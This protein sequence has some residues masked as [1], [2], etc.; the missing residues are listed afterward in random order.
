ML[1]IHAKDYSG[2]TIPII[3]AGDPIEHSWD[4][5]EPKPFIKGAGLTMS[6]V[7]DGTVSIENFIAD[8]DDF[9]YVEFRVNTLP[10][11]K[12]Y[13]VQD[14]YSEEMVDEDHVF[15]LKATD[16]L[17]L[18]K[19]VTLGEAAINFGVIDPLA[20]TI[21]QLAPNKIRVLGLIPLN[22]RQ[23]VRIESGTALDGDY[24]I[25]TWQQ[26][27]PHTDI[28]F[29]TEL[30]GTVVGS[31]AADLTFITP[32][33]LSTRLYLS[34]LIAL[35]LKPT[36]MAL[37]IRVYGTLFPMGAADDRFFDNT[38]IVPESFLNNG[39]WE[40]C[41]AVIEKTAGRAG[42][43]LIQAEGVLNF[44][45]FHELR[46]FG[47]A[48]PGYLYNSEFV[49]QSDIT[50][51]NEFTTGFEQLTEPETGISYTIARPMK[52]IRETFKYK[53]P[54]EI[55][56]NI[57]FEELG[58]FIEENTVGANTE[59]DYKMVGW[60][61]GF[62]YT[63]GGGGLIGSSSE[64][65]IRVVRDA[66]GREVER[67]G[68]VR[69]PA[70]F[71]QFAAIQS[72]AV[73][74]RI[75]DTIEWSFDFRTTRS[76]PGAFNCGFQVYITTTANPIPR[77]INNKRIRYD[78]DWYSFGAPIPPNTGPFTAISAGS[79][80]NQWQQFSITSL[81]IPVDGLL[82][83]Y[84]A[85]HS[86]SSSPGFETHYRNLKFKITR[87]VTSN[88]NVTGHQHTSAQL[89]DINNIQEADIFS[90]TSPSSTI[91]GT[92]MLDTVTGPLQDLTTTWDMG[93]D[94]YDTLGHVTTRE[95]LFWRRISRLVLEGNMYGLLQGG[96]ILS[97]IT[98]MSYAQFSELSFISGKM[99]ID[100]YNDSAGL[101]LH[102]MYKD[103]EVDI[104]LKEIYTFR[105]V[106]END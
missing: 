17:A 60:E 5:D 50:L 90:D 46:S 91:A 79:N 92:L 100:Y 29:E 38:M 80:S 32:I 65:R 69:N 31:I 23:I 44:V 20:T 49:Y 3:M 87:Q 62:A 35:C 15:K 71:D 58:E 64:R 78:G 68:V 54:G 43:T 57:N 104:D 81:P 99:S 70:V 41:Y 75:G 88:S 27:T 1:D 66:I 105:K 98:A 24:Q 95:E 21:E 52:F 34:D 25:L 42:Y 6:I 63:S 12:G 97:P 55:I 18:L 4:R 82:R 73:E 72:N 30:N 101:T 59:T 33:D 40:S 56:K 48:I 84:L 77:S 37:D 8:E 2:A 39:N 67:Y 36:N 106:Y 89:K 61:Q 103:S 13:L 45:R 22:E 51:D 102:E 83:V 9:F 16:N 86:L 7:N 74:V 94:E 19:N 26:I 11:F 10:V 28:T 14:D 47:N 93:G 76:Q 96:K 53:N 85:Q